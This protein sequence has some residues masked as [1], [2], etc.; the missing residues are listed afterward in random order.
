MGAA[1][2]QRAETRLTYRNGYRERERDTRVGTIELGLT[3]LEEARNLHEEQAG[4]CG[5]PEAFLPCEFV[6]RLL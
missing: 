4:Q 6:P 1:P 5:E 3:R 2:H